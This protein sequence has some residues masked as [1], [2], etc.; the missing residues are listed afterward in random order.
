[1]EM[2]TGFQ[3]KTIGVL[4]MTEL[5]RMHNIIKALRPHE[6]PH[7]YVGVAKKCDEAEAVLESLLHLLA[8]TRIAVASEIMHEDMDT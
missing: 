6:Y 4:A 7:L 8:E 2:D 5:E 1:M 3:L